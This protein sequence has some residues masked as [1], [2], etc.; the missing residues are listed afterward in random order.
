M[1]LTEP[2]RQ[3][4]TL[5]QGWRYLG[6]FH[7]TVAEAA[8]RAVVPAE[9]DIDTFDGQAWVGIVPFTI[10]YS[11]LPFG[12][13]PLLPAFHEINLR[14]YVHRNGREPGVWFFSL[15]ATSARA[16]YGARAGYALPYHRARIQLDR[17]AG[18]VRY[19]SRRRGDGAAFAASYT[20]SGPVAPAVPGTLEHFLAERYLL[21]A[22]R[23]GILL[24]ARVHHEPYPLQPATVSV[25]AESLCE[26]AGLPTVD[27]APLAH[28]AAGVDV[29]I[30]PPLPAG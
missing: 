22:R 21:Y 24:K 25:T 12:G 7:W 14:T 6:F 27:G 28:Y 30:Y 23:A 8:L 2:P 10:P 11:H 5:R 9:L 19:A 15:D 16:V 1:R 18:S 26:S 3:P 20:P 13:V 29:R 4:T 17:E